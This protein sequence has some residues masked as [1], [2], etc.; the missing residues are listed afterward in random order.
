[1]YGH[2]HYKGEK[3]KDSQSKDLFLGGK[4][5]HWKAW[6]TS[7]TP[8][9]PLLDTVHHT[10]SKGCLVSNLVPVNWYV[11]LFFSVPVYALSY[12]IIITYVCVMAEYSIKE[13]DFPCAFDI[14]LYLKR[15]HLKKAKLMQKEKQIKVNLLKTYL[16]F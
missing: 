5:D 16:G 3:G 6:A 10:L 12:I 15:M 14:I 13:E 8:L 1:M 11:Y 9:L 7:K 4:W 2:P